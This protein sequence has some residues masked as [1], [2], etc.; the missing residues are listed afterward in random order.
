MSLLGSIFGDDSKAKKDKGELSSL[1]QNKAELPDRP[2]H[3]PVSTINSKRKLNDGIEPESKRKK[4]TR[5]KDK[6]QVESTDGP[7]TE[8]GDS[9]AVDG[10]EEME[11]EENDKNKDRTIFV[12]N[13]PL[14]TT[15]RKSLSALFKDCG[16]IASTRIRSIPVKGIKLPQ[17]RAG[18]QNL[19]R[20]VCANTNQV[21]ETLKDTVTGYVVFKKIES[22][23]KALEINNTKIGGRRIRVDRSSP[24][25]DPSRSVFIGNLPYGAEESSLQHHFVKGCALDIGDVVG[26]RIIRE[27]ET[28]QCKGFGYVLFR[29]KNMIPAALKLHGTVYMKKQLRVLVCG[30]R[31]KGRKGEQTNANKKKEQEMEKVTV[32]AFRRLLSKQQKEASEINKRKRGQ[33]KSVEKKGTG[34]SKRA[35]L[36]KKV[37]K[38]VKKLQKRASKGMGKA[39]R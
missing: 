28:H 6:N 21:D 5:K 14:A 26:A 13:L 3:E 8:K 29:E 16:P 39:K 22:V 20:K 10:K 30:K 17:E 11:N 33:K 35:A 1:F 27:K 4:K 9:K 18:D 19:M 23:E 25:V 2:N 7:T 38:R 15:T 12:G 36:E 37:D 31:L 24:T 34:L 32:G